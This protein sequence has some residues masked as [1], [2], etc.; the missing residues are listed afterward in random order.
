MENWNSMEK[1]KIQLIIERGEMVD[2]IQEWEKGAQEWLKIA[3]DQKDIIDRYFKEKETLK[4]HNCKLIQRNNELEKEITYLK[5]VEDR[6]IALFEKF[7]ICSTCYYSY[8]RDCRERICYVDHC[9]THHCLTYDDAKQQEFERE[10]YSLHKCDENTKRE[11]TNYNSC[12]CNS[13]NSK[14][15]N[16]PAH[17]PQ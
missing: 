15:L 16:K 10:I 11:S 7:G 6:T 8:C 1:S 14:A 2:I 9:T 13:W 4:E 5:E 12:C 3:T 17:P